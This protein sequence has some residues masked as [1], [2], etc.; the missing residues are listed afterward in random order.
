MEARGDEAGEGAGEEDGLG[1]N[2]GEE[3]AVVSPIGV[4][5]AALDCGDTLPAAS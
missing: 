3:D 5:D 4:T 2:E 1:L